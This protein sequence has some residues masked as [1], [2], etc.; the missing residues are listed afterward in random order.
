[1][2]A[3]S[4]H[5]L[6]V[7]LVLCGCD[8]PITS[9]SVTGSA[10]G[11][12]FTSPAAVSVTDKDILGGTRRTVFL[13][14]NLQC[15]DLKKLPLDLGPSA[16]LTSDGGR[17]P[18]LIIGGASLLDTGNGSERIHGST[19]TFVMQGTRND[20]ALTGR[21]TASFVTDVFDGGTIPDGGV[22]GG[23]FVA[24]PCSTASAGCEVT[25]VGTFS[26]LALV[27]FLLRRRQPF[28]V[29]ES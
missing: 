1:M 3:R 17:Q 11:V 22:F 23:T 25:P 13:A 24:P 6:A 2:N 7:V 19:D 8:Q 28:S 9:T 18:L 21:F 27:F 15:S 4:A 29:S 12:S 14:D 16:F 26:V 10:V 5:A 20:G